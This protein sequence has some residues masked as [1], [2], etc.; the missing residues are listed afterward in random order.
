MTRTHRA[1]E[2]VNVTPGTTVVLAGWVSRR[3]D[4][5]SLIFVDLRDRS[6]IVQ[7][8]FDAE[9]GTAKSAME[10][11]NQLR[12]EYV[13][14]VRGTVA[15]REERAVNPKLATGSIE[16]VVTEVEILNGSK[17]PPF[18]IQNEV[19]VDET[20]RLRYRYLDLRR[21][22]MQ[23]MLMLRHR[24]NQSLRSYL[25]GQEFVEVETPI[26][27][28][29]TPEGARDYL[30]PSRLQQGSFYALPQSPQL[31]KQLLMVSGLERYYQFARC[32]R[33]EDL[34]A[35]RQPEFTQLDIEQSF[36]PLD[37]FQSMME[38]MLQG[39]FRD[40]LGVEI[41]GPFQRMSY[42]EAMD[43][44]GSD[45]PDL[46]FGMPIVNL[47]EAVR[48]T[49]F[50]VF[51][52]ALAAGGTV[53]ALVAPGCAGYSRKQVDELT[54]FVATY[55]LKGLATV[56]VAEEGIKSSIAKFLSEDELHNLVGAAGAKTGDLILI[57]A[58][59]ISV[60]R[61]ALGALR[62]KLGE[63]LALIDEN[64]F[65]FLWVVDFPLLSYD[66]DEGRY[67]AEHHP[68]T[69]P[70]WED[71]PLLET[72]PGRVRAQAYDLVLNGYEIGGGS[73][74]IFQRELQERM[75]RALGFTMEEARK[76]F[77]F[78]LDAFEYGTPPHGGIAFGL[79]RLVMI[80]GHGKSLRDCIAFPKTSSGT[81]LL[82]NAPSAVS[83][84]QMDV[85]GLNLRKPNPEQPV[86]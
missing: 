51:E 16:V 64:T 82:M 12:S 33:D 54:K 62:L 1:V 32:F 76:Q 74:R 65:K 6:G 34:R 45:K 75:F 73:M 37:V 30:V 77:G 29:S 35:D 68:F 84:S 25:N 44:Y 63:D 67:V 46:R 80:M 7:L 17:T 48:G 24:V 21:P 59:G 85:L 9:R 14:T 5:G 2:T 27:T 18:Y 61:Q 26:L 50:R 86:V 23:H 28:K 40:V 31:F 79:D 38:Q 66:E 43:S 3:R 81:D 60:V 10:Q 55:G 15:A 8:V 78:L 69:M 4:L 22:E 70:K 72:E 52:D 36:I 58:A 57:A 39:L 56:A 19:D 53:R 41:A 42:A 71:I 83:T 49:S 11:A 13:L 47:E 20:V